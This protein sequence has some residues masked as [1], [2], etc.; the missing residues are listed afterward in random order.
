[1][2]WEMKKHRTTT[3][4]AATVLVLALGVTAYWGLT[5]SAAPAT[6]PKKVVLLEEPTQ[7]VLAAEPI[8]EQ[9][10]TQEE[11]APPKASATAAAPTPETAQPQASA[12]AASEKLT[13]DIAPKVLKNNTLGVSRESKFSAVA[14]TVTPKGI[15]YSATPS[16]VATAS[17]TQTTRTTPGLAKSSNLQDPFA[18]KST[19]TAKAKETN[20]DN[21]KLTE[22]KKLEG[23]AVAAHGNRFAVPSFSAGV[24]YRFTIDPYE[25]TLLTTPHGMVL[26]MPANSFMGPE[27]QAPGI[28]VDLTI[29]EMKLN[30]LSAHKYYRFTAQDDQQTLSLKPAKSLYMELRVQ[31]EA[32]STPVVAKYTLLAQPMDETQPQQEQARE[33]YLLP[34]PLA[35][36]RLG[37]LAKER[38]AKVQQLL[39][40]LN[41]SRYEHTLIATREFK[42]RLYNLLWLEEDLADLLAIY[43]DNLDKPLYQLDQMVQFHLHQV[44]VARNQDLLEVY[45]VAA[46]RFH[47]FGQLYQGAAL[48]KHLA[49]GR[50]T[51]PKAAYLLIKQGYANGEAAR[52]TALAQAGASLART[53]ADTQPDMT[54]LGFRLSQ[55][56]WLCLQTVPLANEQPADPGTAESAP[57]L[58]S[59]Q[60]A[61]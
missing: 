2:I 21:S 12:A 47:A 35:T 9:P 48:P 31:R 40:R 50:L 42:E 38:P 39:E 43:T 32:N 26:H 37:D 11:L 19:T 13:K 34:L 25:D 61:R 23:T 14:A 45:N 55:P 52:L 56:G 60:T 10:H 57:A 30:A 17:Q 33:T 44:K 53:Y 15:V 54:P 3:Y 22:P 58:T 18:S 5:D 4:F 6:T 27:G 20:S 28:Q 51:D 1:M 49:G 36:L 46:K 24:S 29:Q 59:S 8:E 16:T 41:D 7:E